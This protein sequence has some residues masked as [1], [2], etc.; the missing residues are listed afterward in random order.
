[1]KNWGKVL[2]ILLCLMVIGGCGKK[3]AKEYDIE[4][5]GEI[6]KGMNRD[7]AKEYKYMTK[8][9]IKEQYKQ[10]HEKC[11]EKYGLTIGEEIIVSGCYSEYEESE[12]FFVRPKG[13]T[14]Y[15]KAITAKFSDRNIK[16]YLT[17]DE[18]IKI[19]GEFFTSDEDDIT[20]DLH[21]CE[22]LSPDISER[23][24]NKEN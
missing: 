8:D 5:F 23:K 7:I 10:I 16:K 13:E 20:L 6:C 21:N 22:L 11:A 15:L 3:T 24:E 18:V 1:M 19:K 9:E 12:H 17:E 2:C 14:K 4:E